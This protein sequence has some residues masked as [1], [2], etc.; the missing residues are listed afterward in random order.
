M[1]GDYDKYKKGFSGLSDLVSEVSDIDEPVSSEPTKAAK[2]STDTQATSSTPKT[3][4]RNEPELKL[5][6]S[7]PLLDLLWWPGSFLFYKKWIIGIAAAVFVFWF[8]NNGGQSTKKTLTDPSS[9]SPSY[10]YQQSKPAPAIQTP[11]STPKRSSAQFTREAQ[12]LLKDLGYKPGPVDGQYG[13][14]TIAAVRAF[15]ID[16]GILEDGD[17]SEGLLIILRR[18]KGNDFDPKSKYENV[19]SIR[20][21]EHGDSK[22]VVPSD[23]VSLPSKTIIVTE[24]GI[25]QDKG[26]GLEWR[27]GPD[28]D[29]N[30]NEAKSWVQNLNLDGG[31]WRMPTIDELAGLYKEGV[32]D[33]NMTPLFKT[34][35]WGIWS[36]ETKGLSDACFFGFGTGKTAWDSRLSLSNLRAFA[37]RSKSDELKVNPDSSTKGKLFVDTVPSGARIRLLNIRPVF[38]Q[39]MELG[40][41]SYHVEVSKQG[42]KTDKKWVKLESGEEKRLEFRLELLQASNKTSPTDTSP[43]SSTSGVIERDG[44]YVAYANGIVKDT[45][46][47]LEWLVGPDKDTNWNEAK[48][49][50]QG[51]NLDGGG[52]RMPT[53]D[54]LGGLYKKGAGSRN[55]KPLLRTSGWWVWSGELESSSRV[56]FFTFGYGEQRWSEPVKSYGGRAF[57]VRSRDG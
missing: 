34:T 48:S 55:M 33:R 45:N 49:W 15:Q 46:T 16:V 21:R 50:V 28:K 2:P 13:S 25:V 53:M 52:W 19:A 3:S 4:S 29:T 39:G 54:E 7:P 9:S 24:N 11:S 41:G 5:K 26:S 6:D 37:V 51:L 35:G 30:W 12:Q 1:A 14:R 38:H 17:I 23:T 44:I 8:V 31:G 56:G 43:A 32:G 57:A 36:G 20:D 18:K 47:G 40:P 42:Y 22:E 10:N 27:A